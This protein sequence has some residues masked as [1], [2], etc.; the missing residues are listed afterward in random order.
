MN[1]FA[2][3]ETQLKRQ[4]LEVALAVAPEPK[5]TEHYIRV[6]NNCNP[7]WYSELCSKF[8]SSRK[9]KSCKSDTKIKRKDIIVLLKRLARGERPRSI[10]TKELIDLANQLLETWREEEYA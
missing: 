2:I 7:E 5:H 9:R 6:T 4:R 10:Y 8:Q 1:V 3:M